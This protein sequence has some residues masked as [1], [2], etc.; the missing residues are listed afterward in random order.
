MEPTPSLEEKI[1][2][3]S[4]QCITC[5]GPGCDENRSEKEMHPLLCGL[6]LL[7]R[8]SK[9]PLETSQKQVPR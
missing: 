2:N 3:I 1:A 5:D 4:R 6:L 7:K 8:L 9:E